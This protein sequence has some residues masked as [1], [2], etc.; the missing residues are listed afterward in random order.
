MGRKG[1]TIGGAASG[2]AT[3]ATIG[4]VVPGIG[5]GIG[6]LG[7]AALGGLAGYFGGGSTAKKVDPRFA[8]YD[9]ATDKLTGMANAAPRA[10]PTA[11]GA[12]QLAPAQMAES[13]GG[14]LGVANRLGAVASGQQAGAGELAVNRQLGQA[15]AAQIA[16]ARAARGGNA[17][18]AARAAARNTADLG[19]AGAA[20]ASQAQMQ[21]QQGA[22]AQLGSLYGSM[23]GQDAQVAGQNAQLGQ[24]MSLANLQAELAQRGMNDQQQLAVLAQMLGWDQAQVAA[25]LAADNKPQQPSAMSQA[26]MGAG[27]VAAAYAARPPAPAKGAG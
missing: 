2:A 24:A 21:D 11:Q 19:L 13:R 27:Q 20:Q 10:A 15:T 4:S 9:F 12:Y 17:A 18:L 6:A 3:G 1:D 25:K 26:L 22:N 16:A 14:M 7:G 8:S 23:Y 5:T